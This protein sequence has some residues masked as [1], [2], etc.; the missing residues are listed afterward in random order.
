MIWTKR[1]HQSAKFQTLNCSC[2]ISR[3]WY[4]DRLLLLKVYKSTEE[5]CLMTLKTD[6]KLEQKLICCSKNDTH[7]VNFDRPLWSLKNLRFDWFLLCKVYV[8][9]KN[10]MQN[11]KKDWLAVWKLTWETWQ[12]FTRA[13]ESVKVVILMGSLCPTRWAINLQRS[14]V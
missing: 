11:L 8:W 4:F 6:T 12:I 13:P 14:Y 1:A 7:L 2:E 9:P 3:N 5:L 10:F